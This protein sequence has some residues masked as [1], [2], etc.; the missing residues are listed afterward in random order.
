MI[1]FILHNSRSSFIMDAIHYCPFAR[2]YSMWN[3]AVA[4]LQFWMADLE[5]QTLSNVIWMGLHSLLLQ[6]L[7][8]GVKKYI[9]RS[10]IWSLHDHPKWCFWMVTCPRGWWLQQ[11][12]WKLKYSHSFMQNTMTISCINRWKPV[13][14]TC[15]TTY[16]S[17]TLTSST[18]QSQ[19]NM[20]SLVI[21]QWWQVINRYQSTPW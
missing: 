17:N 8:P 20:L 21:Q 2:E 15:Y 19:L 5:P 12:E 1:Q 14:H 13:F 4:A 11:L 3:T 10:I 9:R 6:Q 16:T 18:Q 7:C